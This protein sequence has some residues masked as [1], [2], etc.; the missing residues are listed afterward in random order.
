M[1]SGGAYQDSV[2]KLQESLS[3]VFN[4]KYADLKNVIQRLKAMDAA[5]IAFKKL[6][7][8]RIHAQDAW[9]RDQTVDQALIA[10]TQSIE[11]LLSHFSLEELNS[12]QAN[13]W[14][15]IL[16]RTLHLPDDNL[17]II[18]Q[19]FN[20]C[21]EP[22]KLLLKIMEFMRKETLASLINN[23]TVCSKPE[24]IYAMVDSIKQ[25]AV[26]H[27]HIAWVLFV[28]FNNALDAVPWHVPD[29]GKELLFSP[30]VASSS[31]VGSHQQHSLNAMTRKRKR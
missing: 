16:L 3:H 19:Q 7:D 1:S 25:T 27:P 31:A 26:V 10:T 20:I 22:L 5:L 2:E 28:A 15:E 18:S 17:K 23:G 11:A 9:I 30:D 8:K 29:V 4:A 13:H 12:I 21:Y 6:L 14:I 24:L